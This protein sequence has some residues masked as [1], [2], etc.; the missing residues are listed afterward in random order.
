MNTPITTPSALR[1]SGM[2]RFR[3]WASHARPLHAFLFAGLIL[4]PFNHSLAR[5]W[6]GYSLDENN[7]ATWSFTDDSGYTQSP[8]SYLE[9]N[10][11]DGL[12]NA[13]EY[14]AGTDPF[15]PDTD[16]DAIM[17]GDEMSLGYSP[18]AMDT[19]SD[20]YTD[21]DEFNGCTSVNYL[22]LGAGSGY[23]DWDGDGVV[24][25]LDPTPLGSSTDSDGDGV[26][27]GS[28][29]HPSNNALWCDW[30]ND[31]V[32]DAEVPPDSD[33]DGVVN[34]SD[35]HPGNSALW[36][37]W[38]N[39]GINDTEAPPDFDHD[40]TPDN[41]DSHPTNELLWSDFDSDGYNAEAD[42]DPLIGGLW[43]DWDHDG[44]NYADDSHPSNN[45]LWTDWDEDGHNAADDSHPYEAAYWSD[46]DFD[47]YNTDA[48]SD[49]ANS[50]LFS[51]W[52]HDG[53]NETSDSHP[54]DPNLWSDWDQD[55]HNAEADCNPNDDT[56]WSDWDGNGINNDSDG[57]EDGYSN[58][59]DSQERADDT[60]LP[61]RGFGYDFD[62]IGNRTQASVTFAGPPPVQ[63][64]TYTPNALNQY[65][66]ISR[67]NPLRRVLQ[68]IAHPGATIEVRM[69]SPTGESRT[70]A[71][72]E[73]NGAGFVAEAEADTSIAAVWRQVV[74][75]ATRPGVGVNGAAVK[76]KRSGWLF[77]PP[78]NE[79]LVYDLD[80]NLKEDAR[81][82]YSWD[83]ENRL[84]TM[85]EKVIANSSLGHTP[86][87]RQRLEFA[88]DSQSRRVRKVVKVLQG[89]TWVLKSD[90]RFVY[91]A[92]NLL[93]EFNMKLETSNLEL[94]RS[95]AWGYDLSGSEQGAGGV[96]G[97]VLVSGL[98]TTNSQPS[99]GA[100]APAYDGN[101][102]VLAYLRS[103]I[104]SSESHHSWKLSWQRV[105]I[106]S[107]LYPLQ[108]L[109][110][111]WL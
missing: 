68:G 8:I 104:L 43:S 98:S 77:F 4:S 83:G 26:A 34:G 78:Q 36:C 71:R 110:P 9:D 3:H 33:G 22:L 102:N 88:Y 91:D 31:G 67:T 29:S 70:V 20:G 107:T 79:T 18:L 82:L 51:D 66:S 17:D 63:A 50:G 61:G 45:G 6:V 53:T 14:F 13:A 11:L 48:D 23:F 32:N 52:D 28:D 35:S 42:S 1:D 100:Q 84:I 89:Q 76:T 80:G 39:D 24:N 86:P 73:P 2:T 85:E 58:A 87:P 57:D 69:D 65:T 10:D 54:A 19:D 56:L 109:R 90:L 75:E 81:W 97:L 12:T 96:G 95:Y 21:L 106:V 5:T 101:G 103:P 55:G 16:Y 15:N 40:G 99:T 72:V 92:W 93:A 105:A 47:G 41:S 60:L 62:A 108:K 59:D 37:D 27:D 46:F 94:L 64:T 74:V 49:P 44:Y 7:N 38:N 30:N 25:Y 111:P